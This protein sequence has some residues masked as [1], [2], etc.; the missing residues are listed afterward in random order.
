MLIVST[1]CHAESIHAFVVSE[2]VLFPG[3]GGMRRSSSS[4][5]L[6]G[7]MSPLSATTAGQFFWH[8]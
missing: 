3:A 2:A 1:T 4:R 7:V 5:C 8:L 6:S